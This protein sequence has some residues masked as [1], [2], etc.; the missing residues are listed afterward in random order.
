MPANY[1]Y[2]GKSDF[3]SWSKQG[4]M[5]DVDASSLYREKKEA[6]LLGSTKADFSQFT[7]TS[8]H[9]MKHNEAAIFKMAED[10]S[11][12]DTSGK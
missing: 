4:T 9:S 6:D 7:K 1:R 10:Y 3:E 12:Y 2:P 5:S 8:K 11:V